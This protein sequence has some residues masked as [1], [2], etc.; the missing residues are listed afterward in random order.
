MGLGQFCY[1][2]NCR[3]LFAAMSCEFPLQNLQSFV[4]D[5]TNLLNAKVRNNKSQAGCWTVSWHLL[6][7]KRSQSLVVKVEKEKMSTDIYIYHHNNS[8]FD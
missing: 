7:Q 8:I 2:S 4:N 5:T 6:V 1:Y 3:S